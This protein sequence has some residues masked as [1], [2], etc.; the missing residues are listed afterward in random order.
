M[1]HT[2]PKRSDVAAADKWHIE[3]YYENDS[4]WEEAYTMLMEE[5]PELAAYSGHLG[6]S[7]ATLLACLEK[8]QELS[9][10]LDQVYT[11]ANMRMHED[12]AN[13]FYQGMASRAEM[14][15]IRYSDAISFLT[16]E[17]LSLPEDVLA[18]FR[19]ERAED[20]HLYDHFFDNLLRQKAHTLSPAE[21]SLLAKTAEL[22]GAPQN[23]FTMLNDADMRFG[24][25]TDA[26]GD[27][28]PLTKGRYVTF[29]ESSDRRVRKEA[30]QTLYASYLKQ[31]NTLAATYAASVKSDVFFASARKYDSA[32]AMALYDDNIPLSVYDN[33]IETVHANLHLM[34]RYV[35]LRKNCW[36][37]TKS[38]C[39]IC[40]HPWWMMW[41]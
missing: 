3:D 30:F 16:P 7:A 25:I 8:N 37:W 9:L 33:L 24:D 6:E 5:I 23:I 27:K 18:D 39:T 41:M 13:A 12:S 1:K 35:A 4:L 21:E 32:R 26:D 15:L 34:H 28:V 29:L 20:F 14:L 2:L 36:G 17:I 38:T 40:T 11:Y 10:I 31:K 22:G 19:M